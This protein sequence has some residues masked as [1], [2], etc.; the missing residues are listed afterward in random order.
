M[1]DLGS[2]N[3]GASGVKLDAAEWN[4]IRC[5]LD[6][7]FPPSDLC[8]LLKFGRW[9][10]QPH[11]HLPAARLASSNWD[12][13]LI[14]DEVGLGKTISA[15]HV[16]RRLHAMGETGGILII[17]PGGLRLKWLQEMFHRCDLDGFEANTGQKLRQALDRIRDGES[18]VIVTSHG[19]FRQ[20]KLLRELMEEGIPDLLLT[21]VDESHHCRNPRSRLHDAIQLLSLHSRQTLFLTAT[22][23]NLSNEELW[24]QLSLLAPDR[25]P[26]FNSFQA[27]MRPMQMLNTALDATAKTKPD[28]EGALGAL[29]TLNMTPG[30]TND[31]RLNQAI[32]ICSDPLGWRDES[33]QSNRLEVADLIRQLRPLNELIVRTRRRDLDLHLATREAITLDVNLSAAEWR[34]YEAARR[35]TWRLMQLRNPDSDRFDWALVVPERMAS[36]C[37]QAFATHVQTQLRQTARAAFDFGTEGQD[38]VDDG[39]IREAEHRLLSRFGDLDELIDAAEELGDEDSKFEAMKLWMLNSLDEDRVGGI[40]LFSHFRGTLAYLHRRLTEEGVNCRVL[41]GQTPMLDREVLRNQFANGEIDVLLSSEVGSE[42]LDQQ[43][44]H[45]LVNYDLPWNPMRIEQ[46]IGRLDRFGQEADVITILNLAVEGTIDA[47][48]LGRLFHRIRLFEDSIGMLDPLLGKAMRLVAQTELNNPRAKRLG[49]SGYSLVNADEVANVDG[50]LDTLLE[51]RERWLTERATEEREWLGNDPGIR[52]L[53]EDAIN[54]ELGIEPTQLIAWVKARLKQRDRSSSVYKVD[55]FWHLKL[56]Q[57][58]VDELA[59]R[60]ADKSCSDWLTSGWEKRVEM[61]AGSAPP[62]IIGVAIDR[63]EAKDRTDLVQLAPWH[64]II[65][66]LREPIGG[67]PNPDATISGWKVAGIAPVTQLKAMRPQH[68]DEEASML[69]CLDWIVAGLSNHAVRRWLVLDKHGMPIPNQPLYPWKSFDEVERVMFDDSDEEI[70]EN[71]LDRI[72]GWLLEDERARL[73]PLLDELRHN[74]QRS[75][76]ERI[77]REREQIRTA[78]YRQ[79]QGGADVDDRWRRMKDG[80][81]TR[82]TK[83]LDERILH[84]EKIRE[85]VQAEL[86]ARIIIQLEDYSSPSEL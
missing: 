14:A 37:L 84:L 69:I 46:R 3:E 70:I 8:P 26:D 36:S 85:G 28:L 10:D 39:T 9:M 58:S 41:S 20:S 5:D 40:L 76:M 6:I 23:V 59:R 12:G 48:I 72:H 86:S 54:M 52:Q 49:Q 7:R 53:R 55:G 77:E 17:C 66:W 74:V 51:K 24:V 50:S 61:L 27:T 38:E 73:A 1:S 78:V 60:C 30:F 83:E 47:A 64:P 13:L 2:R 75:W 79:Q 21:I 18:L 63:D 57:Y 32:E 56:S 43:H 29:Q 45:R 42:G 80:L 33:L 19:I 65:Q 68:W 82:L 34:L 35:W 4:L 81:I 62:H 67:E 25:W 71:A 44:C 16:L 11:Q 22:P 15:L 31:P